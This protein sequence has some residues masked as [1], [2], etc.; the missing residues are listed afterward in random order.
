MLF[1]RLYVCSLPQALLLM[2]LAA[3]FDLLGG[4]NHSETAFHALLLLFLVTPV[5]TLALLITE[6]ARY[7]KLSRQQPEHA[8]LLWPGVALA[9]CLETLIINLLIL[10]QV[11]M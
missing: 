6:L 5:F 3:R 7:R 11:H 2:L 4:W 1:F 8:S 10:S 9:L